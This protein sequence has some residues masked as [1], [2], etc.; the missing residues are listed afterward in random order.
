M[1]W[2]PVA[3]GIGVVIYF[4][5][6]REPV[7]WAAVILALGCI[8]FTFLLRARPIAFPILLALT[9][10][11]AGFATAT[12]KTVIIAHPVLHHIASNVEIAGFVEAREERERSDRIVVRA[13]K[14]EG[15]RLDEVPERVRLSVRRGSAPPVGSYIALKARLSPPLAPLRP[16]G[17][18]FARDMFFQRI[19]A[20]D[21]VLGAIKILEPPAPPG[22]W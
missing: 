22:R 12:L 18:D 20:S 2:L 10:M 7:W 5:A 14:V 17:Y 19:G 13:L 15:G 6:A 1:P 4:A 21:Y 16:G 9:A 11:A 3:F 8:A